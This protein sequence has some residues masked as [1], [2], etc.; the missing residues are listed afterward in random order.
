MFMII[1]TN[2][3]LLIAALLF[4]AIS[5]SSNAQWTQL[6]ANMPGDSESQFGHKV[7]FNY[8][9]DVMIGGT[10]SNY[11][12]V[13]HEEGGVWTQLGQTLTGPI[14]LGYGRAVSIN[15]AGNII[16][17]GEFGEAGKVHLYEIINDVWTPIGAPIVGGVHNGYFDSIGWSVALNEAGD[18]VVT[19]SQ[20]ANLGNGVE[21]GFVAVFDLTEGEWEQVGEPIEGTYTGHQFGISVEM[22]ADGTRI[23]V[24]DDGADNGIFVYEELD[25]VWAQLGQ[26]IYSSNVGSGTAYDPSIDKVGNTI[27]FPFY[28]NLSTTRIYTL[29]GNTWVPKGSAISTGKACSL[30]GDGSIIAVSDAF[31]F[32]GANNAWVYQYENGNWV[33]ID[34]TIAGNSGDFLG[35]SCSLNYAGNR[36]LVGASGIGVGLL[37][38][39]QVYENS[40]VNYAPIPYTPSLTELVSECGFESID[41]PIAYNNNSD[42]ITGTTDAEFPITSSTTIVWTYTDEFGLT[43]TQNQSVVVNDETAPSPDLAELPAIIAECEITELEAPTATD[44]C[45]ETV[46]ISNDATLPITASGNTAVTWTYDDGNGNTSNQS[47]V[48]TIADTTAPT[49]DLAELPAIIAECEITELEAPTATDN[50]SESI[51]SVSNDA[52][53]PITASG[54]TTVIWTYDDGNGNT[55]NQSQVVT[56]ED[57]TAPIPDADTLDDVVATCEVLALDAPTATD[58]CTALVAVASDAEFPITTEGLTTVIWTYE[59]ESGNTSTQSQN[60]FINPID[61]EVTIE[62]DITL[63]ATAEDVSYQWLD[64]GNDFEPISTEQGQS[65]TATMTGSYAVELTSG[66]CTVI[67]ECQLVEVSSIAEFSLKDEISLFPNPSKGTLQLQGLSEK[68]IVSVKVYSSQAQL[69]QDLPFNGNSNGE[70]QLSGKAGLYFVEITDESNRKAIYRIVKE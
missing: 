49:P 56:I 46:S 65:F 10:V 59:D 60:V 6:G 3:K 52:T 35:V 30:N 19:G 70:I 7:D 64:C 9:G 58:N 15:G 8:A 36:L 50:C 61:N 13:Y 44:N 51:I 34:Q 41:P 67:S 37:G 21:S 26:I 17:V 54:N 55:S 16:A 63:L 31:Y 20:Y 25:G 38:A 48:V 2:F 43:S 32:G 57:T 4:S 47:Q 68:K 5:L 11:I 18:R 33:Q 29:E 1:L 22:N 66:S 14:G 53:L 40:N 45:A 27:A 24:G 12:K 62:D 42:E 39:T 28:G 69:V 23:V